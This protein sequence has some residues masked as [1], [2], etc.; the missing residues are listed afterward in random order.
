MDSS[1]VKQEHSSC[2]SNSN[3]S[4]HHKG[5]QSPSAVPPD[6]KIIKHGGKV[7]KTSLKIVSQPIPFYSIEVFTQL[8]KYKNCSH[9]QVCS[10][11]VLCYPVICDHN[12]ICLHD[13]SYRNYVITHIYIHIYVCVCVCVCVCVYIYIYIYIHIHTHIQGVTGGTDQNSGGCSL[14]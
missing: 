14:C 11:T 4:C 9:L 8:T 13:C 7:F 2:I 1:I 12:I 5:S 10:F 6:T 3:L